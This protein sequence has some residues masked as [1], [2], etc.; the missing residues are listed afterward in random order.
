MKVSD[1][2]TDF[3]VQ[4]RIEIVFGYMGK[5]IYISDS[6]DKNKNIKNIFSIHEQGSGF[7]GAGY[8]R[9]TGKPSAVVVTSGPGA[10]NIITPIADCYFDGVPSIFIVAD[11]P[12]NECKVDKKVR[13]FGF[14]EMDLV[15]VTKS[16]TKYSVAISDIKNLR[17]E[18]EK[19]H[20]ISQAPRRGPVFMSIP[21]NLHY[22]DD[23]NPDNYISFYGSQEHKELLSDIFIQKKY[24]FSRA[25][26]VVD[27]IEKSS[28]PLILV[29]GGVRASKA[30]KE[31]RKF[32]NNT[33]IPMVYS[34]MGK[35]VVPANYKYNMGLIGEYGLKHANLAIENSDLIIIL[36]SRLDHFQ[37]GKDTKKF[38]K[39]AKIIR[40]DIDPNELTARIDSEIPILQDIKVFLKE[41]NELDWD[42]NLDRWHK[43]LLDY[44]VKYQVEYNLDIP[45]RTGNKIVS[46]ISKCLKDDDII[47]VDVG[48]HQMLVAQSLNVKKS[49]RVLFSGGL[50]TMGFALPSAIGAVLATN[51]RA[52]VISGDGGFQMNLQELEVIKRNNLPIKIFIINNEAL[53]MIKLKQDVSLEGNSVGSKKGYS[54]PNFKK[55]SEAYGIDAFEVK[56]IDMIGNLMKYMLKDDNPALMDIQID[57]SLSVAVKSS[58]IDENRAV[59]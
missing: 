52:I 56:D 32:L 45:Q 19:A 42:L 4:N 47:C 20:F 21:E 13:Q 11:V 58:S 17:Y 57:S 18:L 3:F 53:Q 55:I 38:A 10:T 54:A 6:V 28:N 29:G 39:N 33:K 12:Q 36:G 26:K 14:Q 23:Y 27:L 25:L 7:A 37:I 59:V 16:I 50:G 8:S 44:R 51:R 2:I 5:N 31:I 49:Q 24:N 1:Y 22:I 40:V 35:D 30:V 34:L 43:Q 9:S 41:L 48:E 15:S 46:K